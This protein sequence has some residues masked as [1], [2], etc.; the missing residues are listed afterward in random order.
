MKPQIFEQYEDEVHAWREG[1]DAKLRAKNSWLALYGLT[2]L[3]EG[4]TRIGSDPK[5]D[6][7]LPEDSAPAFM[8]T[9][10]HSPGKTT[11]SSEAEST[12]TLNGEP[13]QHSL[14]TP[15]SS[16]DPSYLE[17]GSLR[18]VVIERGGLTGLRIWDN[19]RIER[20]TFPGRSWFPVDSEFQ[21]QSEFKEHAAG[22][23]IVI[24]NV[25][26]EQEE[27]QSLGTVTFTLRDLEGHLEAMEAADNGLFIIFKDSTCDATT[28]PAGRFLVSEEVMGS[29]VT[30]DFNRSYNP[31]CAFTAFA[32]CPLP[33]EENHLDFP[34]E[35][36][37]KYIPSGPMHS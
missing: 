13:F 25:Q 33:P 29:T 36:G 27:V 18:M 30:L 21:V 7:L 10:E 31:P 23:T 28:Y 11:F 1:M 22:R 3:E 17:I 34:V 14:L 20:R 24:P 4:V 26:G 16:E 2:W 9:I 35:A 37:E 5:N 32:T 8:G 19:N 6:I 12:I 15:D